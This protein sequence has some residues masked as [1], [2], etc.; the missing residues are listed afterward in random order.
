MVFKVAG[1]VVV[2]LLVL[3]PLALWI[4]MKRECNFRI[5]QGAA[6][7]LIDNIGQATKSY[8]LDQ[9]AYPPGDGSGSAELVR[10]LSVEEPKKLAYYAFLPDML[11]RATGSILNPV[12]PMSKDPLA[13]LVFYRNNAERSDTPSAPPVMSEDSFDIWAAGSR[14]DAGAG[15]VPESWAVNNWE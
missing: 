13:R 15:R 11:D 6:E 8:E 1:V 9:G 3:V 14:Y 4:S 10:A 12:F 5:Y 7:H 2:I